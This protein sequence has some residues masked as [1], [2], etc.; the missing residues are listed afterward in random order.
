MINIKK[1][2]GLIAENGY[3]QSSLAKKMGITPKTFY[4]KMGKGVFTNVE[5]EFLIRNLNI[6]NPLEIFFV[7]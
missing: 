2:K 1:L 5:I 6:N 4:G 3:S 7:K